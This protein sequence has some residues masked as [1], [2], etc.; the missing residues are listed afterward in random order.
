MSMRTIENL[1]DRWR[2][3]RCFAGVVRSPAAVR[4][5]FDGNRY[6]AWWWAWVLGLHGKPVQINLPLQNRCICIADGFRFY[7]VLYRLLAVVFGVSALLCWACDITG[8]FW[9]ASLFASGIYLW[10][11]AG[12]AFSGA[13]EFCT[14]NGQ[15]AWHLVAFLFFLTLFLTSVLT[16]ISIQ[17]RYA[18]LLPDAANIVFT[19]G[20][21]LFGVGSY[22]VELAA[23]VSNEPEQKARPN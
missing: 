23:L 2:N 8:S 13:A 14:S 12:L 6:L 15:R 10:I 1:G 18:G 5:A 16:A 19:A 20:M 7:G 11:I 3:I 9:T 17:A 21:M 4:H 22:L